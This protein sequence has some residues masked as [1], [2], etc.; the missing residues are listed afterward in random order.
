MKVSSNG[1]GTH[2]TVEGKGPWVVLSHSLACNYAMW[3]EQADVLKRHYP[4]LALALRGIDNAFAP[5]TRTGG[6]A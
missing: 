4:A 6:S 1:I 5:W 3:D 2:Y